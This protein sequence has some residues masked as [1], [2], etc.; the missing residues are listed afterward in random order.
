MWPIAHTHFS[1]FRLPRRLLSQIGQRFPQP[2]RAPLP[3]YFSS[4]ASSAPA[5]FLRASC[6]DHVCV[7]VSDV[8]KSILWY[9]KVLGL[10]HSYKSEPHF[11][12]SDASSPAFLSFPATS[13]ASTA[14]TSC[15]NPTG[16]VALLPLSHS[17]KPIQ[18]H[19][20]AHF[21]VRVDEAEFRRARNCL[22]DVLREVDATQEA[23]VEYQDYGIQKSLFFRDPDKNIVEIACW[24]G[25]P[26]DR[27]NKSI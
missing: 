10:R 15:N 20:G 21:A 9:S 13:S 7:C 3:P 25:H 5:P 17:S 6:L 23:S 11:F 12:P 24:V 26:T 14:S 8:E 1:R 27:I 22:K 18:D 2:Q 16:G 4:S 19:L